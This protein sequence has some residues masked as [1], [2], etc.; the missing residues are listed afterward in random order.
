MVFGQN[1]GQ[2][3]IVAMSLRSFVYN[4]NQGIISAKGLIHII[5]TVAPRYN[6]VS[7][8]RKKKFLIAG[9]SLQ[10]KLR[11]NELSGQVVKPWSQDWLIAARCLSRFL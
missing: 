8:Y 3:L 9:S 7:R 10:R 4:N 5:N 1:A 6:E 11:Y 2:Q